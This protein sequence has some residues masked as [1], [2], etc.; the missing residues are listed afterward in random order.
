MNVLADVAI[1]I[2]CTFTHVHMSAKRMAVQ[3]GTLIDTSRDS[4][5]LEVQV[6]ALLLCDMHFQLEFDAY[7]KGKSINLE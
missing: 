5:T 7:K 6:T 4:R 1:S 3:V 2:I